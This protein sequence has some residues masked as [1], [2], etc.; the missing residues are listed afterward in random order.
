MDVDQLAADSGCPA[1][2]SWPERAER[3]GSGS[4]WSIGH[5]CQECVRCAGAAVTSVDAGREAGVGIQRQE[6]DRQRTLSQKVLVKL[7]HC[8]VG[9][10]LVR[11]LPV[12]MLAGINP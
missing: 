10:R 12:P 5:G 2:L 3:D 6:E 8:L 7:G 11:G 4:K 1:G 9:F